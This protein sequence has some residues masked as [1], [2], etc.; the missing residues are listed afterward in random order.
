[1]ARVLVLGNGIS[2]LSHASTIRSWEGE[3]WGCNRAYLDFPTK[4]SRLTGHIEVL[5]EAAEYK[6]QHADATFALWAGHLGKPIEGAQRFTCP[7]QFLN[8]SG[9]TLIAQ[10]LEEG[11]DAYACGFD[12]G[13]Y[14]IHS[15]G[16]ETTDKSEWVKRW[17]AIDEHYG[18]DR[19]TFIGFDHKPFIR[20]G[21]HPNAYTL[22]YL[23]GRPHIDDPEYIAAWERWTG[24]P[25][26]RPLG[27]K[28][29]QVQYPNGY[30][31]TVSAAVAAVLIK[32][33]EAVAYV[34]P[35]AA[36]K[37]RA[38][39]KAKAEAEAKAKAEAAH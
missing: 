4:L 2:R 7:R 8:D 30:V 17:R 5:R 39:A 28:S 34:D 6:S 9:T 11:H 24:R 38:E 13:G 26:S 23:A 25:A 36:K 16:L 3:V 21:V 1:M 33:K 32:N 35:E 14:D 19:L 29:M 10:A 37:G 27:G 15:P 20:S 22:D 12:L 18:L 31:G